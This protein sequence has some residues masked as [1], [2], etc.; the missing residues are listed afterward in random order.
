[1]SYVT[2]GIFMN[3]NLK[4]IIDNSRGTYINYTF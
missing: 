1:M 3:N 4:K 2:A